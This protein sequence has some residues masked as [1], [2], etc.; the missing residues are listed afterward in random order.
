[1]QFIRIWLRGLIRERRRLPE[2]GE[3]RW[4]DYGM[5]AIVLEENGDTGH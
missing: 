3:Q 2:S 5:F 4:A 1:M